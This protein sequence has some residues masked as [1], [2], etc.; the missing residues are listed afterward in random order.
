MIKGKNK[1]VLTIKNRDMDDN[2]YED[3]D[4]E[5]PS[6]TNRENKVSQEEENEQRILQ[7]QNNVSFFNS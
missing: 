3:D 7:S 5:I 6:D 2:S 4:F 1:L